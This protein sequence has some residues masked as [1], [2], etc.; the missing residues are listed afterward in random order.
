MTKSLTRSSGT[1]RLIAL[2][3]HKANLVVN[4]VVDYTVALLLDVADDGGTGGAS[5]RQAE[6]VGVVDRNEVVG[7]REVE[8]STPLKVQGYSGD[9]HGDQ[10]GEVEAC[11]EEGE[12]G[13]GGQVC[14]ASTKRITKRSICSILQTSDRSARIDDDT[15]IAKRVELEGVHGNG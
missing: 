13:S 10:A 12:A 14:S 1:E 15:S 3:G 6:G 7:G 8:V 9:V 2:A 11:V 4:I 5:E